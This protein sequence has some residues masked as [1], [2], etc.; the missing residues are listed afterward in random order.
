MCLALVRFL[1]R[2]PY[3]ILIHCSTLQQYLQG[4]SPLCHGFRMQVA[5]VQ[6]LLAS[7]GQV[8][9]PLATRGQLGL[10]RLVLLEQPLHGGHAV[11]AVADHHQLLLL[12]VT[13]LSY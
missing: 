13:G 10:Q 11:A 5:I 9:H 8:P 4:S 3:L 6:Q 2:S 1:Q 7:A 12:A